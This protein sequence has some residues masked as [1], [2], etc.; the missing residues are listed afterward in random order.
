MTTDIDCKGY[1]VEF[2]IYRL[3]PNVVFILKKKESEEIKISLDLN[4]NDLM[5]IMNIIKD[6]FKQKRD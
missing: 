5:G 2:K 6:Y 4:D 1:E 3:Y